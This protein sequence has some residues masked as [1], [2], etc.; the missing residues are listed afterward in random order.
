M[1]GANQTI[2]NIEVKNEWISD[3]LSVLDGHPV[4]RVMVECV[5]G[6]FWMCELRGVESL[7]RD[8]ERYM[9]PVMTDMPVDIPAY[10]PPI[11]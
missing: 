6:S 5:D 3:T 4:K 11:E 2:N 8:W 7:A 9:P 10:I 1:K